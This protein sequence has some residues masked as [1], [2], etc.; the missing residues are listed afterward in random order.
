M[1][2]QIPGCISPDLMRIMMQMGHG[3]ELV[4]ADADF[5]ADMTV[6]AISGKSDPAVSQGSASGGS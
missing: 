1:L 3:D 4:V 5:P 6:S 2:K